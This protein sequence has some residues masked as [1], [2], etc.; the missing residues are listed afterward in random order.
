MAI[1]RLVCST[2]V[3]PALVAPASWYSNSARVEPV[4]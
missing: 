3:A 4:T 2:E 1:A